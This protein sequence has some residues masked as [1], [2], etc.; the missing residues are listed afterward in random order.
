MQ[1]Q[2]PILLRL[3]IEYGPDPPRW[4]YDISAT[5]GWGYCDKKCHKSLE[6]LQA[7][8]LQE[9]GDSFLIESRDVIHNVLLL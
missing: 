4:P 5:E 3:I 9:V 7:S 8:N 6:D 1:R 2:K